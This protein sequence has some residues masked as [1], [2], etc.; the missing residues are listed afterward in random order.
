M[1][2]ICSTNVLHCEAICAGYFWTRDHWYRRIGSGFAVKELCSVHAAHVQWVRKSNQ[3]EDIFP[4]LMEPARALAQ[5]LPS[6][7]DCG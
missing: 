4:D 5:F 6:C 1:Q 2:L 7:I 3:L